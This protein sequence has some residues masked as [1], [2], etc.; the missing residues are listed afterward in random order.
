MVRRIVT[1]LLVWVSATSAFAGEKVVIHDVAGRDVT[2][3][4]PVERLIL[5]EGRM[6]Y[7]LAMLDQDNPFK[8]VVGWRDDLEK[9]DP[10]SWALY[11][12]R[13]PDI[14]KIPTFGGFKE[15]T[16]DIEQAVTLDPDVVVMNIEAQQA[17]EDSGLDKK[18][19]AVGIPVVYVDFRAHPM[20]NTEPSMKILGELTGEQ[21][22]AQAFLDF[23]QKHLDT[24]TQRIED[25][26]PKRPDVFIERAA[27]YTEECCMSFG[28][29]NFGEMVEL[30][31]GHNIAGDI[32]P[33][34]FGTLNPEQIIASNPSQYIATG[35][36]W[37]G[38]M[39]GGQ[40]IPM[41]PNSDQTEALSRLESLLKRPALA[42]ADAVTEGHTHA[43]WHQFYNSPYQ[44]AAI[45]Q[46]A[47]W[48]HPELFKD[49]DPSATMREL[50]ER[51]LPIDYAPG[52]FL[53]TT[54]NETQ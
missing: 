1:A 47:K 50:H 37:S 34:T 19:A 45:E 48:I 43:I 21:K 7:A 53:S 15:G 14:T 41:G 38:Y 8:R 31:G 13:Y 46:I 44:F 12:K 28:N 39:P 26:S 33:G 30:A 16:F 29:A 36:E 2:V 10:G 24:V 52:Y 40:W 17:T 23:R 6:T 54:D 32:I 42:Q 25:A 18:L 22:N 11:K 49:I 51:F 4:A 20:V 27:G 5:G 35:G 9:A 3:N